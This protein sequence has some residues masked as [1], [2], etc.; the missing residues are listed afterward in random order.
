MF[1][2]RNTVVNSSMRN[3]ARNLSRGGFTKNISTSRYL[4]Q[5]QAVSVITIDEAKK[6]PRH[7]N[8]MPGSVILNMAVSGNSFWEITSCSLKSNV[9][10][11][12][13]RVCLKFCLILLCF[14][15]PGGERGEA[16][17]GDHGHWQHHVGCCSWEVHRHNEEQSPRTLHRHSAI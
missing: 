1:A 13:L 6:M 5:S 4:C 9:M 11:S 15:R 3:L 17:Q 7:Y 10:P 2:I 12:M 16:D 14:R 8:E